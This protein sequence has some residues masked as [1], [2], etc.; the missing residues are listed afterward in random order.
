M[1]D[2]RPMRILFWSEFY[3]P[4]I[5][6]PEVMASRLLPALRDRGFRFTVV[7]SQHHLDL[8]GEAEHEGIPIVRLP[9]RDAVERGDVDTLGG[10][11]R[12]IARLKRKE[13]PDLVHLNGI[14][15]SALFHLSTAGA[16]PAPLL[17][18]LHTRLMTD[19]DAPHDTLQS[20]VLRA[21]DGVVACSAS[22]LLQLRSLVP[23]AFPRSVVIPN[24]VETPDRLPTP[25]PADP[26]HL[27]CL[28][29]LIPL[30]GFD[31]ALAA[32]AAVRNRFP[33]LRLTVAGDGPSRSQLERMAAEAGLG[34]AVRFTGWIRPGEIPGLIN[35]ATMVL[36]PSRGREG[37]PVVA[38]QAALMGRPIIATPV[39]GL[40]EIVV[41]GVTGVLV[42]ENDALA[43]ARA[44]EDLL[45]HPDTAAAMGRRARIHARERF[46]WESH[47]NA[48]DRVYRRLIA[49]GSP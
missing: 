18:T 17:V 21:A 41:D 47:L 33:D 39:G 36:I 19:G 46:G 3:W 25:L 30:K 14:G 28:G 20:R 6:G 22:V 49:R 1:S 9:F 35:E 29:R 34:P 32:L 38:I 48:Y 12:R 15:S 4:Y 5:G 26:A 10:V 40:P 27:L 23:T 44:I 45:D 31:L 7:T 13:T 42:G 24:S 16:C 2:R 11:I 8:P 37:L 43:L